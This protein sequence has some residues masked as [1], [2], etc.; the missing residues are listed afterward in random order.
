MRTAFNKADIVL[1]SGGNTLYARDRWAALGM[2]S[3]MREAASNGTVMCGGSAGGIVWFDGGHSD[4]MDPSS[5]KNP[6]GPFLSP[7]MT[8]A[9]MMNWAYIRV[10]GLSVLPGLFCPHYDVTES[11]GVLRADDFT[12]LLQQHVGETGVGVDNWAAL[13]VNGSEYTVVSRSGYPGSV[14]PN[15]EFVRDDSGRP[16]AWRTTVSA[17][18]GALQ[19]TL[20]PAKGSIDSLLP[21]A[22]FIVD[23]TMLTVARGQNPADGK[24]AAW[25]ITV[26]S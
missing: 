13:M 16:G 9:E 4:S 19:R 5:Y 10:P 15:G 22:R 25:N 8:A 6:P 11:N 7:N 23:T 18:T 12:V 3:L 26:N 1:V 14:G 21:P 2:D 20:V 17:V 24:P